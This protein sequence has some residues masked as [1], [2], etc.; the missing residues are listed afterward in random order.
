MMRRVVMGW[1]VAS[2]MTTSRL[3]ERVKLMG[4]RLVIFRQEK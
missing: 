4:Q 1:A 2:P 3:W